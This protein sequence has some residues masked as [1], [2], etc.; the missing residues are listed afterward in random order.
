MTEK[1][2]PEHS[3]TFTDTEGGTDLTIINND[4]QRSGSYTLAIDEQPPNS[5]EIKPRGRANYIVAD[6]Q[7]ATVT[8]T[9]EIPLYA[10][11]G[12]ETAVTADQ[13]A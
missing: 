12:G 10:E 5:H 4:E 6:H 13:K 1:L 2:E 3:R 7:S 11:F 9:G 8:N